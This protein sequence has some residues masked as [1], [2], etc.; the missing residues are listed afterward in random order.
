MSSIRQFRDAG[1]RFR[2]PHPPYRLLQLMAVLTSIA[3]GQGLN[4]VIDP[5]SASIIYSPFN[6]NVVAGSAKTINAGAYLKTIFSGT[7]LAI[8]TDTSTNGSPYSELW[9][10]IDNQTWVQ[11]TLTAN[12][13]TLSIATQL[14]NRKHLLELIVKST[15]EKLN[16]WSNSE[17]MVNLTGFVIDR[18][19]ELYL[20]H[21]RAK[22]VLIYGD[23]ITEGVR[24]VD[25]TAPSDTD[26]N[27]VQGAYSYAISTAFDAE[28]GIVA[29]GGTGVT[30]SGSGGVPAL[31]SSYDL[32]YSGVPRSFSSPAPD[33][34]IYNEGTNDEGDITSGLVAVIQSIITSAPN[35]KH[36][37]FIPFN[38]S[39]ASEIADALAVLGSPNV[40]FK[41]TAGFFNT[42]DS[43]DGVH[44]YNYS[45]IG[46]IA[47]QM[48]P[49]ISA[50][51]DSAGRM[52]NAGTRSE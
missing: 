15:S 43:S 32:I 49:L 1:D 8:T 35:S 34:V 14:P 23:S 16:R 51:L 13:P 17:T 5:S 9:I 46:L 38:N 24:T 20:P 22:N 47:P 21:R 27:D 18:G 42:A 41:S 10:R 36:L 37:V 52:L 25:S 3:T 50:V 2:R 30:T 6:W 44:P 11:H 4:T 19:Q 40:T 7:S 39:H 12:N 29:F 26:R 28:V 48:F 31:T 45:H 33:L